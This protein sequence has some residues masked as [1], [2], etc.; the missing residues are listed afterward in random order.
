MIIHK[1]IMHVLDKNSDV[2]V[3]NDFEGRVSPELDKFLSKSIKKVIKNDLLRKAKFKNY[4]DNLLKNE[5]E[6][7]IYHENKF[8]ENS[9]VIASSLFDVIK[10]TGSMDSCDLCI[11]LFTVKDEKYLAILKLDYKRLY[12]HSIS[13]EDD[14][15]NIQ[16]IQNE[17]GILENA[18][19]K[20]AVIVGLSGMNDEYDL[21]VLDIDSERYS[22]R[23]TFIE[24]F[25][26]V[27]KIEDDTFKTREFERVSNIFIT[28]ALSNDIKKAEDARSVR[29]YILRENSVLDIEKFAD[30]A[31]DENLRESF[32]EHL[33]DKGIDCDFNIDKKYIEKKLRNRQIKTDNGFE[34]KGNRENFEDPMK[35]NV[36]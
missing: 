25:L 5:C 27:E 28:N 3:L 26:K 11:C 2:T 29:D 31:F 18:K 16:M 22:D 1:Y 6:E 30:N 13:F 23:S 33:E 35:Y 8:L 24:E 36:K 9:K 4:N 21:R 15:F 19:I 7:I 34:I 17:T 14:K 32:I 12:N 20:Q 10:V